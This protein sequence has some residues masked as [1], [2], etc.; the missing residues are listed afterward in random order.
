AS[1]NNDE[2]CQELLKEAGYPVI[3]IL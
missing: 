3:Q 2:A 1:N